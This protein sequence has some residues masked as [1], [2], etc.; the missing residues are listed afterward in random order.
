ML[1]LCHTCKT[2]EIPKTRARC[3]ECNKA[4]MTEYYKK[5]KPNWRR[6]PKPASVC[7]HLT[8]GSNS[9]YCLP[10]WRKTGPEENG[11]RFVCKGKTNKGYVYLKDQ[12]EYR[13]EHVV[14]AERALGRRLK[15]GEVVHH[16][17]GIKSDNRNCNLL[18]C[19]N[20]YHHWLHG[21]MSRRYA[22]E[23]FGGAPVEK[24]LLN[25]GGQNLA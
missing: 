18:I 19:T 11:Y 3:Y 8:K 13:M 25:S 2:V 23:H 7:G 21:E 12:N 24:R 10:C 1:K 5:N 14:K 17:N 16:I 4:Y 20:S 6:K 22:I 9:R 15:K